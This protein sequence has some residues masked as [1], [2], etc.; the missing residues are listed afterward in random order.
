[1][2]ARLVHSFVAGTIPLSPE[3]ETFTTVQLRD[4][5]T[6]HVA[7]APLDLVRFVV[8]RDGGDTNAKF[9]LADETQSARLVG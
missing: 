5:S 2:D 8:E 7:P 4:S 1:M 6:A 9:E 3:T